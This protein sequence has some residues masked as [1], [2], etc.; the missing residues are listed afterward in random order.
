VFNTASLK[1]RL[2]PASPADIA[3]ASLDAPPTSPAGVAVS[4]NL[5]VPFGNTPAPVAPA[6]AARKSLVSGGKVAAAQLVYRKDP[7]VPT[8][9]RQLGAHGTVVLEATIG[10]DGKVTAVKIVSGHPLLV[11]AA[12]AAVMQWRYRPTLLDGQPVENTTQISLDFR[13]GH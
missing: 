5:N 13:G 8:A 11:Q 9:A 6:P 3:S 4:S 7:E 1:D 12:K 2:R 10:R